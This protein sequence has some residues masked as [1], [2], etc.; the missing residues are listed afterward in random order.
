MQF[1]LV[2]PLLSKKKG[3]NYMSVLGIFFAVLFLWKVCTT[4][5]DKLKFILSIFSYYPLYLE[6]SSFRIAFSVIQA[7]HLPKGWSFSKRVCI[8]MQIFWI[9]ILCFFCSRFLFCMFLVLGRISKFKLDLDYILHCCGLFILFSH[10]YIS[11]ILYYSSQTTIF[12]YNLG[13]NDL[14]RQVVFFLRIS[15][16]VL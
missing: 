1:Q 6:A 9:S 16:A 2:V 4:D 15:V 3:E 14:L 10:S 7:C 5:I 11:F 12:A 8:S 13:N